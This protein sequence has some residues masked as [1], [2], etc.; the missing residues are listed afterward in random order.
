MFDFGFSELLFT[1]VVALLVLG[2]DRL[3]R[4][5]KVAGLW[6]RRAR[7]SWHSMKSQVERELADDELQRS[8]RDTRQQFDQMRDELRQP[9]DGMRESLDQLRQPLVEPERRIAAAATPPAAAAASAHA[10]AV[11]A[12]AAPG[13]D[14]APATVPA[15]EQLPEA[16]S[17]ADAAGAPRTGQHPPD[18]P[19][20]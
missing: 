20:E 19:R 16:P 2:P 17:E 4:A 10:D 1:A 12:V 14:A 13:P 5:A 7:A 9:L 6:V 3:P 11:P 8:L 18:L 15:S